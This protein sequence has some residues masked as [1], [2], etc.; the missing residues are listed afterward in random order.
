M[1]NLLSGHPKLLTPPS[2]GQPLEPFSQLKSKSEGF[3]KCG[4]EIHKRVF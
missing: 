3:Y 2:I 4:I 1:S